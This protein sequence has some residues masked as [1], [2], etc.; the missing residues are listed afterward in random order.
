MNP[1]DPAAPAAAVPPVTDPWVLAYDH[2]DPA[3]EPLHEAL[4]ALGNGVFVTRGAAEESHAD[5]VHY[6]GTYVAGGY[7]RLTPKF[8][9]NYTTASGSLDDSRVESELNRATLFGGIDVALSRSVSVTG[10]L[11]A[12]L[13]DAASVSFTLRAAL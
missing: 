3:Q 5:G 10:Q 8:D 9:V 7:N 11:Y 6:P 1:L 12:S 13:K 4:C 2:F